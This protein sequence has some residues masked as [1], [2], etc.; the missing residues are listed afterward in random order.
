MQQRAK[1]GLLVAL[2]ASGALA[3]AAVGTAHADSG[4][5]GSAVGSPGVLSGNNVQVPIHVPVNI[6]GNTV[7]VV[8]LLNPAFG[9]NCANVSGVPDH[10]PPTQPPHTSK[11]PT[12][13]PP[14]TKP[15]TTHPPT[16]K[17]PTTQPP[18]TPPTTSKP[19]H[20]TTGGGWSNGGWSNGGHEAPSHPKG[21]LAHTGASSTTL[22][23]L[24]AGVALLLGGAVLYRRTRTSGS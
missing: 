8:G 22:F 21:E 3:S 6:C 11:P 1:K 13:E 19:P 14:T 20:D 24:P 5:Q 15:P 10:E 16:T 4:A 2:A 9:N 23:L 17:P 18:K 12:S 7:N